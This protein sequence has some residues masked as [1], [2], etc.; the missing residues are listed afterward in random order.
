MAACGF[1]DGNIEKTC[2]NNVGGIK[3]LYLQLKSNVTG[4]TLGSPTD[5]I[6]GFTM[7]AA[8]TFFEVELTRNTSTFLEA[9]NNDEANG[10]QLITQTITIVLNRREK[11]KRDQIRLLGRFRELVAIIT[12]SNDNIWYFGEENGLLLTTN[13][14]GAGTTKAD[15]NRY[16]LTL[17]AQEPEMANTVTAA[18]LA[19]VI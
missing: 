7:L 17:V 1:I 11:T 4:V 2:D 16:T 13:E 10:T 14:G 18:A 15:P 3:K 8:A 12:D 5:E 9:E 19:A 6:T